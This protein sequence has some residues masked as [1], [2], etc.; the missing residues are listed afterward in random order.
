MCTGVC[1][2]VCV[3]DVNLEHYIGS[4]LFNLL[5]SLNFT[6]IFN[7]NTFTPYKIFTLK[8]AHVVNLLCYL[9]KYIVW[10]KKNKK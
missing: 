1:V 2:C 4:C 9:D 10:Q 7:N 3:E 8:K 6:S 5:E